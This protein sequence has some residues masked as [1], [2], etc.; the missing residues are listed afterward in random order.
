MRDYVGTGMGKYISYKL[1]NA[2]TYAY[3]CSPYI[4]QYYAEAILALA[5]K[6]IAVRVIATDRQAGGFSLIDFFEDNLEGNGDNFECFTVDGPGF[7]HSKMYI[8]DDN[9]AVDGSANLTRAGLWNQVN[10]IHVYDNP[11]EVQS[12]KR[13]F[14]K[15]WDYNSS[16]TSNYPDRSSSDYYGSK[17][18]SSNRDEGPYYDDGAEYDNDYF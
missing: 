15:I 9:Y 14:T 8:V 16:H 11:E 12:L 13:S 4:D 18:S 17:N 2:K 7:I 1:F 6:G 5:E 3:I 10:N